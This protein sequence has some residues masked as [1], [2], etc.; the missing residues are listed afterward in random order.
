MRELM[1]VD[2]ELVQVTVPVIHV[3]IV[4]FELRHKDVLVKNI[5]V[6]GLIAIRAYSPVVGPV[7]LHPEHVRPVVL[8][9]H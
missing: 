1:H 4:V 2:A 8:A 9:I 3:V 7:R 6:G 5:A